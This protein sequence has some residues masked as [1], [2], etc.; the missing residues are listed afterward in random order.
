MDPIEWAP[1]SLRQLEV[2]VQRAGVTDSPHAHAGH[3]RESAKKITCQR[4]I[5]MFVRTSRA[6]RRQEAGGRWRGWGRYGA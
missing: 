3:G 4:L 2:V 1:L 5:S 6:R